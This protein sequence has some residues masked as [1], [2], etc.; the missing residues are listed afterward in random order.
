VHF[1]NLPPLLLFVFHDHSDGLVKKSAGE[2]LSGIGNFFIHR[3]SPGIDRKDRV[4]SKISRR[5]GR[6]EKCMASR[7]RNLFTI[8]THKPAYFLIFGINLAYPVRAFKF[9]L[10]KD[11]LSRIFGTGLRI[12]QQE[13]AEFARVG[14]GVEKKLDGDAGAPFVV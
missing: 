8:I 10:S 5:D 11:I 7:L 6:A 9:C 14:D 3:F 2:N 13:V 1:V 12:P 4:D